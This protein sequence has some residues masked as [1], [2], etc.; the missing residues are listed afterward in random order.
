MKVLLAPMSDTGVIHVD[1]VYLAGSA[2]DPIA[3][4]GTA[5]FLEHMVFIGTKNRS[6]Q[7]ILNGLHAR[8][9]QF[10]ATTGLAIHT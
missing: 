5:H 2:N 9:I 3:A 8:G 7:Q 4:P 10:N 6:T 1:L